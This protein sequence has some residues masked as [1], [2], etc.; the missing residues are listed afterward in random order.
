MSNI[1]WEIYKSVWFYRSWWGRVPRES[2]LLR[3]MWALR[4]AL[5][6]FGAFLG[7]SCSSQKPPLHTFGAR[8]W[9]DMQPSVIGGW[10][11]FS[12]GLLGSPSG[13]FRG[14]NGV[15]REGNDR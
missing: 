2:L 10:P 4:G 11:L 3:R 5:E 8:A 9:L 7:R 13:C 1:N 15:Y 12:A 6:E 14:G